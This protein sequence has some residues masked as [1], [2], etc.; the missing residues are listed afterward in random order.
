MAIPPWTV[1][2]LRRGLSDVARRASEPETIEK[3]KNQASEILHDL[4]ETAAR[5][6]DAVMRGAEAGKK[7]VEKWSRKHTA[8]AIP[9]LNASGVLIDERGTGVPLASNVLEVGR[10]LMSGDVI[11]GAALED[12][13]AH[14]LQ[15]LIPGDEHQVAVTSSFSSALTALSLLIQQRQLVV[16]RKHAVRLPDGRPLPEAFGILVPVIQEVGSVDRIETS[17]FDG[18]DSFCAIIAD[19]GHEPIRLMDFAGRDAKQAVVLPVGT[20]TESPESQIPSAAAMLSAGAD[21]VVLPGDGVCGGPGCGL[22]IGHKSDIEKIRDSTAWP[23]LAASDAVAAMMAVALETAASDVESIPV[24]ALLATSEENLRGRAER[25][26]TRLSGS[27]SVRTCQVTANDAKFTSDGRWRFPSRQL[28]LRHA[29]MKAVQWQDALREDL[30]AV[31]V[32]VDGE[33][34]IVDLR[35]I[36][37][38]NDNRLAESLS[39]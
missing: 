16:H 11:G 33:D 5:G 27:D 24:M 29:S 21:F 10:E 13:L 8:I 37:A 7:K 36:A 14:R 28:R 17:D 22:L 12:R 32:G 39:G 25:M 6:I 38:A 35:W 31:I 26:A 15:R 3:L 18:L 23:A 4:P 1:E 19:T 20:V 2:L 34:V 9:M 30:P